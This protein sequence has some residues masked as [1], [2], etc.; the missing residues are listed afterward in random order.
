MAKT[1]CGWMGGA[2][3]A[4]LARRMLEAKSNAEAAGAAGV[5]L[6]KEAT[7]A[8]AD[9]GQ[10]AVRDNGSW[11]LV[12]GSTRWTD[13]EIESIRLASGAPQAALAAYGRHG[14]RLLDRLRGEFALAVADAAGSLLLATD[15]FGTHPIYYTQTGE[16][17]LFASNLKALT[18]HPA[19]SPDID[20]QSLFDYLYFHCIPSP[21][22]IFRGIGKLKPAE[23]VE[24]WQGR[25]S[26]TTYWMPGPEGKAE[27]AT[28]PQLEEELRTL[29][30]L[31]VAERCAGS[32]DAP[33][34]FLSGGLDSS[35][36]AGYLNEVLGGGARTFTIGF[37][38][39]GYDETPY[40]RT[41]ATHFGT[42]HHEYFVKP[43]DV[44]ASVPRIAAFY[45]EPF[46]NSSAVPAFHCAR[47][48]REAG[49]TH[50]LAGDGGDEL[51]AGNSRY[52]TQER[53]ERYWRL[54][55]TMR[56]GFDAFYDL[57]PALRTLPLVSKG[58]R[59]IGRAKK[60]LP[61]RLQNFNFM[62]QVPV[63]TVLAPE[64]LATV[65]VDAPI[66][67]LRERYFEVTSRSTLNRMLYLDWKFT[68]ADNDLAKVS[69]MCDLA[70][71]EVSYPMLDDR[72][73][74]LSWRIPPEWK[75]PGF[76]LRHFYKTALKDFLAPATIGKR[77]HG[78]GLPFGIWLRDDPGLHEIAMDSLSSLKR[79]HYLQAA[80]I[81]EALRR[82]Q[83]DAAHYYGELVWILMSL[84][85]WF[86]AHIGRA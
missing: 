74:E 16:G 84:E 15:R 6:F 43:A 77:K 71:I 49:V 1:F 67:S 63:G 76:R 21:K 56:R 36:V 27:A 31:A 23:R 65:E 59:Y 60:P 69:G 64:V 72:L 46:G 28:K 5:H 50:L 39:S 86:Q 38:A 57:L 66:R 19:A 82:H 85:L 13:P 54:P 80:F 79:R 52:A 62:H 61:D 73:V 20:P 81:D 12:C 58:Y 34:A 4:V 41:A 53:F 32:A 22:T 14:P 70:G 26:A 24:Y 78:F 48:A 44:V 83:G 3:D 33:G 75:M 51:F 37:D 42:D 11:A 55:Q 8:S 68:L 35:T 17:L 25:L 30:R 9:P 18:A 45:D 2:G 10:I 7:I 40:A 47:L 29:L